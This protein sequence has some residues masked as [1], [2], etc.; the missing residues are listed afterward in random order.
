M[1]FIQRWITNLFKIGY[2]TGVLILVAFLVL[3]F[4]GYDIEPKIWIITKWML[5]VT[6]LITIL[7]HF[8]I[9]KTE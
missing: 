1:N 4:I 5:I 9:L 8:K 3:V 6:T 7:E 2:L